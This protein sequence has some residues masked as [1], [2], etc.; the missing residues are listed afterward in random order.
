[1]PDAPPAPPVPLSSTYS[2]LPG[3]GNVTFSAPLDQSVPL[4]PEDWAHGNGTAS[5]VGVTVSYSG[6]ATILISA[7]T[8]NQ[9][10]PRPT[11]WAY[12]PGANPL[13]GANGVEV[14]AFEGFGT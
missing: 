10:P 9:P 6:P 3:G 2:A 5:R 7:L 13:R 4:D 12:T 11:G 1:M 14:A 8:S